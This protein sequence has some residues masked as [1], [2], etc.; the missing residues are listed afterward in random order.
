M[1]DTSFFFVV[2]VFLRVRKMAFVCVCVDVLRM[3]YHLGL[4][5]W[6]S[7]SVSI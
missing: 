4:V 6:T 2:N 1:N 3:Y 5:S 7:E